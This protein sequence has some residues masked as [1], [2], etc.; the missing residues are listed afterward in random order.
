MSSKIGVKLARNYSINFSLPKR[1]K[2]KI[3]FIVLHYTGMKSESAAIKKLCDAKSKV[4]AH[5]YIKYNGNILQL[6]PDLYEAWHAGKSVWKNHN[7]LN[8]YSIGIEISNPGHE[9]GYKNFNKRQILSLKKLLKFLLKKYN[10]KRQA[11][12]GHSDI[13]PDRKKDPGE[14][15]PWAELAKF[16]LSWT[17]DLDTKNLIKFRKTKISSRIEKKYFFKNLRKLGYMKIN[18]INSKKQVVF[19]VKAFQR[20]FRQELI[21]GIL[22]KECFLISKNLLKQ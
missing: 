18:S 5:Y 12:L 17:H 3:K 13:A 2:K 1:S 7:S 22:D 10:I 9:Y 6:V 20:R 4:S 15:F 19:L 16:Q 21:N 8:K 14:K 11:V